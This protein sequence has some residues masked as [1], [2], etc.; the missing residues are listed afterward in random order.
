M[1]MKKMIISTALLLLCGCA[2]I[3]EEPVTQADVQYS[4]TETAEETTAASEEETAEQ[5]TAAEPQ[6]LYSA[7]FFALFEGADPVT[8]KIADDMDSTVGTL[9]AGVSV[10]ELSAESIKEITQNGSLAGQLFRFSTDS[11]GGI[12]TAASDGGDMNAFSFTDS[13]ETEYIVLL[14]STETTTA[15][16]ADK[17]ISTC[18]RVDYLGYCAERNGS[19]V[20][21]PIAAGNAEIGIYGVIPNALLM[22]FDMSGTEEF[23]GIPDSVS[24][25]TA[26]AEKREDG[27]FRLFCR[28]DSRFDREVYYV[29]TN[30]FLNGGNITDKITE[31]TSFR[32]EGAGNIDFSDI[33]IKDGDVLYFLGSV[34]ESETDDLICDTSLAV[35]AAGMEIIAADEQSDGGNG[36]NSEDNGDVE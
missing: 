18:T 12:L 24:I 22:G 34:Y 17:Y 33:E 7:D 21:M 8:G 3:S 28:L 36:E 11:S 13:E 10:A 20:L 9:A 29:F 25:R 31:D 32:L 19:Y 30:M 6:P 2:R 14:G 27:T 1:H 26:G 23:A 15:A 4:E 16:A 35:E 5:E